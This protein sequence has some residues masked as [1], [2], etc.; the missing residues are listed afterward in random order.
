MNGFVRIG[1]LSAIALRGAFGCGG[2]QETETASEVTSPYDNPSRREGGASSML[3][4][5]EF[6]TDVD[7]ASMTAAAPVSVEFLP[8][9]QSIYFLGH[10]RDLPEESDIEVRWTVAT[11]GE[12]FHVTH[13]IGRGTFT[14]LSKFSPDTEELTPGEYWVIVIVNGQVAGKRQFRIVNRRGGAMLSVKELKVAL[15]VD[16][17]H[18]AVSPSTSLPRGCKKIYASFYVN[19]VEP[20]ATIRASWYR[21]DDLIDEVDIESTG[22]ARYSAVLERSG[23]LPIGDYAVEVDVLGDMFA[24]RSFYVGDS[25]GS[26]V[27]DTAGLGLKLGKNQLPK[28]QKTTFK[29]GTK[30]IKCGIQFA[31]LPDNS[32]VA[33]Q[34]VSMVGGTEEVLH[35][36]EATIKKGGATSVG[37]GWKPGKKLPSGPY[38]AMIDVNDVTRK[39]LPFTVE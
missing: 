23:A 17:K 7:Q 12:P 20:G 28:E 18:R 8:D 5:A 34:W 2:A 4:D 39:E 21:D 38:K 19:G 13:S 32:K 36:S 6:T 33:I 11:E 16:E 15:S 37:L 24:R 14:A 25:S 35:V 26:P 1:L 22:E 29:P 3:V 30:N 31:Y 10:L 27:I 9:T